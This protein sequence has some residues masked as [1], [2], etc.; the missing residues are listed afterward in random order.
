MTLID[1]PPREADVIAFATRWTE[2]LADE[3]YAA[4]FDMLH[5]VEEYPG[6][7]WIFSA[8]E[9]R[10]W[11][12]NYGSGAPIDDELPCKVSAIGT[13]IGDRWENCLDLAAE[14]ERYVGYVGHLDWW[15]PLD[16]EW[17]DLQASFDLIE[18]AGQ[19]AFVLVALRVP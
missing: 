7:S 13:A 12:V 4:A 3:N 9:L 2:L 11:I 16:G 17:S 1:S 6:R 14:N 8:N 19:V 15:L 18:L 5:R 10:D